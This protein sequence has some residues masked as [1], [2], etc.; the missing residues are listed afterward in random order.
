MKSVYRKPLLPVIYMFLLLIG[1]LMLMFLATDVG[2]SEALLL[3]IYDETRIDCKVLPGTSEYEGLS[4]SV[5]KAAEIE[6]SNYLQDIS[7]ELKCPANIEVDGM[8]M[9]FV[10][11]YGTNNLQ[12]FI[13]KRSISIDYGAGENLSSYTADWCILDKAYSDYIGIKPGDTLILRGN[14]IQYSFDEYAPPIKLTLAGTYT[15]D[16]QNLFS[17]AVI[18]SDKLYE[19]WDG[20]F[21]NSKMVND[22]KYY[23]D[24]SFVLKPEFNKDFDIAYSEIQKILGSTSKYMLYMNSRAFES[25]VRPLEQKI[26]MEEHIIPILSVIFGSIVVLIAIIISW[27]RRKDILIRLVFGERRIVVVMKETKN[28]L[29]SILPGVVVAGGALLVGK[30]CGIKC[31]SALLMFFVSVSCSLLIAFLINVVTGN[32]LLRLYQGNNRR[33]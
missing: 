19:G 1:S 24:Y 11:A 10:T 14:Q 3:K 23:T 29:Y 12:S 18:V 17:G 7:Y 8:I 33:Q 28:V 4:F 27:A 21:Y 31:D 13:D 16:S 15:D 22:W 25:T 20:L 6:N 5:K 30:T 32:N 26:E 2:T 9:A